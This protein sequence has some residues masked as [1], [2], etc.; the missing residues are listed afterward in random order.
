M[1]TAHC[2]LALFWAA[3][4]HAGTYASGEIAVVEDTTGSINGSM[5]LQSSFCQDAAKGLYAQFADQYDGVVSFSTEA[6]NDLQ[7]VQQGTPVRQST[8]GIGY[9]NWN[10]GAAYGSS[11]KL[12]QCVFMGSLG[13]LPDSPDGPA[14]VLFGLPLGIS[15]VELLGHE[16][17]HH[18]LLWVTFD[19]NDGKGPQDLLR[20]YAE[21]SGGESGGTAGSANGHWSYYANSISPMYGSKITDLGAGQYK[22]EGADRKYTELDQY[23]MGLRDRT[24]VAPMWALD[25]GTGHG[26]ESVPVPKGSSAGNMGASFT[27]VDF[28]VDDIIRA[29]GA[30][31]PAYP[32]TQKCW[33]VAFVLVSSMGHTAT[34]V[35]IAKL[36][37]YRLRFEQWFHAATD[38]RGVMDTRLNG[39]GCLV[40]PTDGGTVVVDAGTVTPDAGT[41]DAG[42]PVGDG[43][44]EVVVDAGPVTQ[45]PDAGLDPEP[46][47]DAGYI[48][49]K[50]ETRVDLG[51]AKIKPGCGCS[52]VSPGSAWVG[53]LALALLAG[54]RRYRWRDD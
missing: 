20:G 25:N 6:F 13:K 39:N 31:A 4:A 28:S 11:A 9:A 32:N 3:A 52:G 19:K 1:K 21:N 33:R 43:G 40:P 27:K 37:A 44:P 12:E 48:P 54:L 17:G 46:A 8:A 10:N 51:T 45:A 15:G 53:L 50:D 30:R 7:N 34:A 5:F 29:E 36:D 2:C 26:N 35:E 23:L 24:E 22:F 41:A 18:W 49:T 38:G 14:T 42:R 16:Y 47:F